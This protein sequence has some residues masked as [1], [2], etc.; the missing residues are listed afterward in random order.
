[1]AS[2]SIPVIGKHLLGTI[3]ETRSCAESKQIGPADWVALRERLRLAESG[4]LPRAAQCLNVAAAHQAGSGDAAEAQGTCLALAT[5]IRRA[6]SLGR[7]HIGP[8]WRGAWTD[9]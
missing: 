4:L 6:M 5:A 9:H 7:M 8:G 3:T 1:M 2:F